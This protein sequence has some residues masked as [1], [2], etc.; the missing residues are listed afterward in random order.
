M[1]YFVPQQILE[2]ASDVMLSTPAAGWSVTSA[3]PVLKKSSPWLT[4]GFL[5]VV[6]RS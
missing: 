5:P 2:A 4:V 1:R 6:T 3:T